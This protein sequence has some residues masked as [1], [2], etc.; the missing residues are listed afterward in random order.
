VAGRSPSITWQYNRSRSKSVKHPFLKNHLF[1]VAS[2]S[3]RVPQ[4]W[5]SKRVR[6]CATSRYPVLRNKPYAWVT[7]DV[8]RYA[9]FCRNKATA[10]HSIL[11]QNK[12]P[13]AP[14]VSLT[15]PL[16]IESLPSDPRVFLKLNCQFFIVLHSIET[17]TSIFVSTAPRNALRE[18][19]LLRVNAHN[20]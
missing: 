2:R 8:H 9:K 6:S 3:L 5:Q 19:A 20:I 14:G 15:T 18:P 7:T 16:E 4:V 17:R 10:A 11:F 12:Y 13:T 1:A